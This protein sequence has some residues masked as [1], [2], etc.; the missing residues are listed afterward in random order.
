[1]RKTMRVPLIVACALFMENLDTTVLATALP[2]VARSLNEDPLHLSLAISSYLVS[3][4]VFIPL[5][6]WVA[7]R[8]GARLIFR[9]AIV[10]FT[11]GSVLCGLSET[12]GQLVGA[13]VLQGLGGAM[14]VPVGRLL[15]LRKTSKSELVTAMAYVTIPALIAPIVGPVVGG[16]IATYSSWRWIFFINVPIGVLGF[17]LATRFI[18]ETEI[19]KPPALDFFG[20]FIVGLGLASF[21][22]GL[23]NL[24]KGLMPTSTV[25]TWLGFGLVLV[26]AYALRARSTPNSILDLSLFAIPTLRASIAGGSLFRIGVGA[27]TIAMPLM[28]QVGFGLT[29]L[30]SGLLTFAGA[31]GAIAMRAMANRLVRWF[32][33]RSLLLANTVVST[34]LIMACGLLTPATPHLMILA[35]ILVLGFS[36]SLQFTCIGTM[37]FADITP[38]AMSQATSLSGTA[39][40][41]SLSVGVGVASQLLH[42]SMWARGAD[43]LQPIDF[44]VT[45]WAVGLIAATSALMFARLSRDAGNSV[46]GHSP[47]I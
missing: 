33:F 16:F 46:S 3:L 13:R 27:Y 24:G 31:T 30:R 8:F 10:V 21:V 38:P 23:E 22:F 45:F 32:G 12:I 36:R 1:M 41:L 40:Q 29:P 39:Q 15:V 20:W 17:W 4:A 6:G 35:L 11:L 18:E 37:G 47:P 34:A 5:S 9:S 26:G 28:L 2:A 7:E 19:V 14:M 43:H 42:T 25:L 44:S